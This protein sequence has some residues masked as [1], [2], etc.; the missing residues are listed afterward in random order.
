MTQPALIIVSGFSCAGKTTLAR[1]IGKKLSLPVFGRDDFKESLFDSLGYCDRLWSKK[2]GIASYKLL[3]LVADKTLA[4]G[5]SVIVESNFKINS[6]TEKLRNIKDRYQCCLLQIHCHVEI[7]LALSRFKHRARSDERHPGHVDYLNYDEMEFNF[8]QGG[9]EILDIC[10]ATIKVDTTDF[11][12][13]DYD[14]IFN[15]IQNYLL[16]LN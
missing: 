1:E 13:I 7:S 10:N 15:Q 9:Y 11:D 12:S 8:K 16:S 4:S 5:N 2:V 14:D 6:D 3:Y